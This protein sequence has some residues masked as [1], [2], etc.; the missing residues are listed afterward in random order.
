MDE[1]PGWTLLDAAAAVNEARFPG[2]A[3][4]YARRFEAG[5]LV[6]IP[7]DAAVTAAPVIVVN[8]QAKPHIQIQS[9]HPGRVYA[10]L[11]AV[12]LRQASSHGGGDG[13]LGGRVEWSIRPAPASRHVQLDDEALWEPIQPDG[14]QAPW[15][16]TAARWEIRVR[17]LAFDGAVVAL[18]RSIL[19]VENQAEFRLQQPTTNRPLRAGDRVRLSYRARDAAGQSVDTISWLISRDGA[20]WQPADVTDN[21]WWRVPAGSGQVYLK[22]VYVIAPGRTW[23]SVWMWGGR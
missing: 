9:P 21:T 12:H 6:T 5:Q 7:G 22:A 18:D 14:F 2:G 15:T 23:E 20:A 13:L 16:E 1:L 11:E 4:L 3:R 17:L 8:A 10:P 19:Q